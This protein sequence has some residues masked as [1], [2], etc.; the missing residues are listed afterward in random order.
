MRSPRARRFSCSSIEPS[1]PTPSCVSTTRTTGSVAAIC[2]ALDG[3]PLAIELAASRCHLLTL[4]QIHEQLSRPLSIGERALRDLP[5][6]QQTLRATIAWS[7]EL[8]T[9]AGAGGAARR[10]RVSRRVHAGS[11]RGGGG[12]VADGR[13]VRAPRGQPRPPP[14]RRSRFELLELVRAFALERCLE[15]GDAAATAPATGGTS[16]SSSR[17]SAPRSTRGAAAGEL[18]A[19]LRADHANLRAAFADA[20]EAGDQES[21]TA[22]ALGLRPLWIAGNLRQESGELTERLLD[23]F[24]IPGEQEMALLRIVA[25]LEHPAAK[26]Q[27]RF[28]ERAAELGDQE[29]LGVATTQLFAEAINARDREEM[30]RLRPVLLSPDRRPRP[31]PAC[32]VGSTTRCL[33][34]RT[35]KVASRRPTSTPAHCAE[36]R[37]GDRAQVHAGVCVGGAAAG[38]VGG[39]A[40]RSPS[41][42]SPRSSSWPAATA[43]TLWPLPRCGSWPATP[44][45]IDR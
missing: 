35:S 22:V 2:R 18:S 27:R 24:S 9:P 8:L 32:S 16:P 10:R 29:A 5:D 40:A 34:R 42:T 19:P 45:A 30:V 12:R 4:A 15:S 17:R 13:A 23:R 3:L 41:P 7:Y 11:P 38:R 28:A 44:A 37:H 20:V 36:L 33:A 1:R 21:A 25:A 26:W 14:G 39:R 6:R 43:S 31:A